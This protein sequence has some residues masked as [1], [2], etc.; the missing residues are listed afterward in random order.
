[1]LGGW[2]LNYPGGSDWYATMNRQLLLATLQGEPWLEVID[3]G[4][5]PKVVWHVT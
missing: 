2:S 4:K 5:S 1:M 3:G